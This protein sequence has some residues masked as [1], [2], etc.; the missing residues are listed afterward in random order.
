MTDAVDLIGRLVD[1]NPITSSTEGL[2]DCCFFCGAVPLFT[3]TPTYAEWAH[4][5]ADCAWVEAMRFLGRDLG[6]HTQK[7]EGGR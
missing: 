3:F 6:R 4:H 1:D 7:V 2:D 5:E